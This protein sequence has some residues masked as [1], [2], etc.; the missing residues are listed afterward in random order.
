MTAKMPRG[1][2]REKTR[3]WA[4]RDRANAAR[5]GIGLKSRLLTSAET[6]DI[7]EVPTRSPG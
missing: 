1:G 3:E 4:E 5:H 2:S 7:S 6:F